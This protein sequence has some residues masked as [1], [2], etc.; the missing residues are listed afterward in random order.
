MK[1]L[2]AT[3]D[4]FDTLTHDAAS[5]QTRHRIRRALGEAEDAADAVSAL[6]EETRAAHDALAD[7]LH[8]TQR[9]VAVLAE[10]LASAGVV[11]RA[12][13]SAKFSAAAAPPRAP[14]GSSAS[15]NRCDGCGAEVTPSTSFLRGGQRLCE[16]CYEA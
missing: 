9:M 4:F 12:Q 14:T 3:I 10:A 7:E 15:T 5:Y 1:K 8:R 11:D 16:G 2:D 13:L 6:R